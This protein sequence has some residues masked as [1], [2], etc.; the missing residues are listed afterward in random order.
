MTHAL[1]LGGGRTF[2]H[3]TSSSSRRILKVSPNLN[4]VLRES[5]GS[6]T[7]I[8]HSPTPATVALFRYFKW[9]LAPCFSSP[10]PRIP[11]L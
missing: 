7:T 11:S 10:P 5:I 4:P 1:F 8:R 3:L 6:T 9:L 2:R